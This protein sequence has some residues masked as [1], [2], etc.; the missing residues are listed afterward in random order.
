MAEGLNG[1]MVK[2]PNDQM[3]KWSNDQMDGMVALS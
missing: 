1:Q 2:W 3:A